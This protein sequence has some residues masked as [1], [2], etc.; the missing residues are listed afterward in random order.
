[1]IWSNLDFYLAGLVDVPVMLFFDITHVQTWTTGRVSKNQ[2][3][4]QSDTRIIERAW[5]WMPFVWK[6]LD[7]IAC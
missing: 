3:S 2:C 5:V 7:Y 6:Y 4:A 1:M